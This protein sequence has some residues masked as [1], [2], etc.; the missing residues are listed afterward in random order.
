[1]N[2]LDKS[3]YSP[4]IKRITSMS[5]NCELTLCPI[6]I[7]WRTLVTTVA[8]DKFCRQFRLANGSFSSQIELQGN[9]GAI[10]TAVA[11]VPAISFETSSA[12]RNCEFIYSVNHA[13]CRVPSTTFVGV[14]QIPSQ[15]H[16]SGAYGFAVSGG[17]IGRP[18]TR[19]L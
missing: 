19:P 4:A 17:S 1:M 11:A 16:G 9:G 10:P 14:T 8:G 5:L 6:H 3:V 18:A 15:T 2:F 12:G 13:S 7:I